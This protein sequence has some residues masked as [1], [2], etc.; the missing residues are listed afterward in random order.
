MTTM[1]NSGKTFE[2]LEAVREA[3]ISVACLLDDTDRTVSE[4]YVVTNGYAKHQ[5]DIE[6][7]RDQIAI[8]EDHLGAMY[9]NF[10]TKDVLVTS[11]LHKYRRD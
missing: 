9:H 8:L 5:K 11:W 10:E 2:V 1:T 4:K 7:I 6:H 3:S